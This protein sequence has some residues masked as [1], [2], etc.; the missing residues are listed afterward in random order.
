[1]RS[2]SDIKHDV[3]AELRWNPDIESSDIAVTVSKGIVT[4][5]GFVRRFYDKFQAETVAKRVAGVL[6]VA[7]DLEVRMPGSDKRPDPDIVRDAVDAIKHRLPELWERVKVIAKDGHITLDGEVEWN[8]QRER[9]ETAVR[10]LKG[11]KSVTNLIRVKP[12]VAP[13]EVKRRIEEAFRRSAELD[14]KRVAVEAHADEIILK[15]TVRSWA[16]RQEAE[17]VAWMA[18]GV[19]RVENRITISP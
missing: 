10:W 5:T 2:D 17:R 13:G 12:E 11:V 7:N 3:E 15:G 8:Y 14:A 16:E 18:P 19:A 1:M 6:G 9:A 4:L